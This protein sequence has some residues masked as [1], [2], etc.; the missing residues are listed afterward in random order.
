MNCDEKLLPFLLDL[1]TDFGQR[2]EGGG[3]T[4][5]SGVGQGHSGGIREAFQGHSGPKKGIHPKRPVLSTK[6]QR[7]FAC[8][9]LSECP[10]VPL[11]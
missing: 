2:L 5:S 4:P 10:R 7:V 8:G 6:K 11:L 3:T 1:R 9:G